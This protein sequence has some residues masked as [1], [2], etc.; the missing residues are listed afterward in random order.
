MPKKQEENKKKENKPQPI[1]NEVELSHEQEDFSLSDNKIREISQWLQE[2]HIAKIQEACFVLNAPN[3]AELLSKID[4][5]ARYQLVNV[6][7]DNLSVD[8]FNYLENNVS[9]P[10]LEKMDIQRIA[11]LI[12]EMDS[13]DALS[14]IEDLNPDHQKDILRSLSRTMRVVLEEGLTFPED[15]AGRLMQR[16]IVAV[17]QFWTVGKTLDYMRA[18]N[19]ALPQEFYN[20]F[21]V[22][23]LHKVIGVIPLSRLICSKRPIKVEDLLEEEDLHTVIA[24]TDQEDVAFLF[25]KYGLV[26]APVV[27]EDQRLLG[28]ITFDDIV[29]VIDEEAEEDFLKL[30][31]VSRNTDI[32]RAA[33]DTARSR[34]SWL[35]VNLLTA[36]MA[37]VVIGFFE[38]SIQQVVA[39]AVLMP[40]VASMGGNAGTQTLA[41]TVR[42]LAT[43]ELSA[44]NTARVVGKEV[45]VGALNGFVFAVITGVVTWLWF[46]SPILGVVIAMAMLLNL[47][48]AGLAGITIPL[49]FSRMGLDPALAS[50]VF[51]TTITDVLGFFAFLGLASLVLL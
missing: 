24:T 23:P 4:D 36:I 38:A 11:V 15:S 35:A 12:N 31:G 5:D 42:A 32:Y 30:G 46:S 1:A 21:I 33:L 48:A 43:K 17:P 20:I 29:D 19:H 18:A 14:L 40:I 3:I 10:I 47:I 8:V 41:V 44:A 39:L 13:D 9:I 37:S 25:R 27:D 49:A 28:V 22:N 34:F 7:A 26:S 16:E 2:G 45:M 50:T 6:L 51:L